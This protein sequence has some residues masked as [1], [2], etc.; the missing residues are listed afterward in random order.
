M[1]KTSFFAICASAL[2]MGLSACT[3]NQNNNAANSEADEQQVF[4][5]EDIAIAQTQYGKVQGFMSRDVYTF[6]GVRYGANTEGANRFM[7]P[8]E[9][10]PWDGVVPALVYGYC[11]PQNDPNYANNAGVWRDHW[12]YSNLSEDC[13]FVNVWTKGLKDGKKRPVMVWFHGGGYAAGNGIEQ[14]GYHGENLARYGDIVFVSV[15]HRLNAFGFSDFSGVNGKYEDSGNAGTLDMVAALKWVNKNI[16]NFGGDPNNVTI[17]G[18]SGGG[19]KVCTLVAMPETKGLVHKAVALSGNSNNATSQS[20]SRE[21]GKFI[22]K[23]S[24]KTVEQLQSMPWRDYLK[25]ANEAAQEFNKT[26]N[27]TGMRGGFAPVADGKHIPAAGYY[28][29]LNAPSSQVP[30]IYCS[31]MAEFSP[32]QSNPS[33]ENLDAK[34][35]GEYLDQRYPGKGAAVAAAYQKAFPQANA[36]D[37]I[38]MATSPRTGI[39]NNVSLKAKQGAPVYLAWFGFNPPIF[40]GRAR[41]FHCIDICFWY[42]NTDR[43]VTHSGGGKRPRELSNKMSDAL[44]AFMR[45]GNPNCGALPEWPAFNDTDRPT[46]ILNDV[47]EVRN[48]VDTEALEAMK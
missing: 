44:L 6:L 31:T 32:A 10:E 19:A 28:D 8:Q 36:G 38:G 30:M 5:G 47:C 11:A 39:I 14:D 20:Y 7:P 40:N 23:Y 25:L 4:I 24:K 9:P 17:M 2:L 46:M 13:L 21:L 34:G 16:E 35:L 45:T 27:M 1:K 37:I 3:G 42:R 22:V 26:Q 41:A 43:M 29:D 12:N 15:N 33:L 48:N 18:Q